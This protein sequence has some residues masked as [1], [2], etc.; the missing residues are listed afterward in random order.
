M[1]EEHLIST[2]HP[3][4]QLDEEEHGTF[5]ISR[6]MENYIS[7]LQVKIQKSIDENKAINIVVDPDNNTY[8]LGELGDLPVVENFYKKKVIVVAPHKNFTY[9]KDEF[10]CCKCNKTVSPKGWSQDVRMIHDLD[11]SLYALFYQYQCLSNGCVYKNKRFHAFTRTNDDDEKEFIMNMPQALRDMYG[12]TLTAKSGF[13]SKIVQYIVD[14]SLTSM[15]FYSM[16]VGIQSMRV[17][18]YLQRK[19]LY[20]TYAQFYVDKAKRDYAFHKND[21]KLRESIRK[22]STFSAMHDRNG[23]NELMRPSDNFIIRIFIDYAKDH[24]ATINTFIEN[25]PVFPTISID[26]TFKSLQ[27][28]YEIDA[29]SDKHKALDK[30][31]LMTGIFGNGQLA[32]CIPCKGETNESVAIGLKQIFKRAA[33]QKKP[34]P[35]I[36][37][38]DDCCSSRKFIQDLYQKEGY[39]VA[40]ATENGFKLDKSNKLFPVVAQDMKHLI[41]RILNKTNTTSRL[42]VDF[43]GEIHSVFSETIKVFDRLRDLTKIHDRVL[44]SK[45]LLIKLEKVVNRYKNLDDECIKAK[46][47]SLF[48]PEFDNTYENQKYHILNCVT[49]FPTNEVALDPFDTSNPEFKWY[50]EMR[51]GQF[52]LFRGTNKNESLHKRLNS[53]FPEKCGFE[54]AQCIFECFSFDWCLKRE[55]SDNDICGSVGVYNY[56]LHNDIK[57]MVRE[58]N[59]SIPNKE[60]EAD[61]EVTAINSNATAFD[62]RNQ[63]HNYQSPGPAVPRDYTRTI[64]QKGMTHYVETNKVMSRRAVV[65]SNKRKRTEAAVITTVEEVEETV[66]D[67]NRK[68]YD[69]VKCDPILLDLE[70]QCKHT[71][72]NNADWKRIRTKFMQKFPNFV[73]TKEQLKSYHQA[74]FNR[75]LRQS[76]DVT[77]TNA[78]NAT[79]AN[80]SNADNIEDDNDID[81]TNNGNSDS[82]VNDTN[83]TSGTNGTNGGISSSLQITL[84]DTNANFTV[85]ENQCLL[86]VISSLKTKTI[87]WSTVY[88]L[89]H[90]E[91]QKRKNSNPQLQLFKRS[92]DK[93]IAR[94]K[95]IKKNSKNNSK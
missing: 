92:Q 29:R 86:D 64:K 84:S 35:R 76:P 54:L 40:Y 3:L 5:T 53:I 38:V 93:L 47:Q 20:Y 21:D 31:A 75:R 95:Q 51:D 32:F 61:E 11:R 89:Y 85:A 28:T 55:F 44:P 14:N 94:Y 58:I 18:S 46:E 7:E 19:K 79:N 91:A 30:K 6:H 26:H 57:C 66:I 24:S 9:Y 37:W 72:N 70:R 34:P 43:S 90:Q 15:S 49:D 50:S 45:E 78:T 88:Y 69:C 68:T 13:T 82:N 80:G 16:G 39:D 77:I 48:K 81:D 60:A 22:L 41:N 27:R 17:Q 67:A 62:T 83:D 12:I 4:H 71:T 59:E 10:K 87:V 25:I 73:I 33:E 56:P 52:I 63:G 36:V 74:A 65:R 1:L 8:S 2:P 42:Y 23:Y